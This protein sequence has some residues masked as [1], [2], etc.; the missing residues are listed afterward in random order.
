LSCGLGSSFLFPP[1]FIFFLIFLCF[2]RLF[3]DCCQ[4]LIICHPCSPQLP[5]FP[6]GLSRRRFFLIFGP[7]KRSFGLVLC[8]YGLVP[9]T[10]PFALS[11]HGTSLFLQLFVFFLRYAFADQYYSTLCSVLFWVEHLTPV[12]FLPGY[13]LSSCRASGFAI[14]GIF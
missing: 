5:L 7:P 8:S 10:Y 3:F 2:S 12:C 4:S 14:T 6:A 13:S 11:C 1:T 9:P